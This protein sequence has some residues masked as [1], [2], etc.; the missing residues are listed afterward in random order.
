[1]FLSLD[2]VIIMQRKNVMNQMIRCMVL[3]LSSQGSFR[4]IFPSDYLLSISVSTD[5]DALTACAAEQNVN[6]S[7]GCWVYCFAENRVFEKE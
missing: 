2:Y 3:I 6:L 5:Y 1:M 7:E 4:E